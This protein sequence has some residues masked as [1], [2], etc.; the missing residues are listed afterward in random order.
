MAKKERKVEKETFRQLF[1]TRDIY[2]EDIIPWQELE[3]IVRSVMKLFNYTEIRTPTFERT[4]LFSRSI[5]SE[6]DI[7]G[8]EMYTFE[9]RDG[10]SL[11]LRPEGTAPVVRAFIQHHMIQ[12]TWLRKFAFSQ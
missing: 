3:D 2:G 5:G 4:E 12:K 9:D 10:E 11:T 6:T 8:K 1:G 7:V